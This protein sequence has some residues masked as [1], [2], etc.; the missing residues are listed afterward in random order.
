MNKKDPFH[1]QE[2]IEKSLEDGLK[3]R[4]LNFS[5]ET[6]DVLLYHNEPIYFNGDRVGE[7]SS[8]MY[9]FY[10]DKSLAMGY[11]S[12]PNDDAIDKMINEQ[13]FEIEVAGIKYNKTYYQDR[14]LEPT[15]DF[16]FSIK[17]VPLTAFEQKFAN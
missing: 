8:G 2:A 9:G 7:I 4:K 14:D 13:K 16:M 3:R 10:L 5:L 12:G 15:E 6:Q 11:I 1:G 17:L